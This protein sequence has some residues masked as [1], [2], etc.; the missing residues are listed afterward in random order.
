VPFELEESPR[1]EFGH[2][3]HDPARSPE[4]E[5]YLVQPLQ[6]SGEGDT[7]LLC[8]RIGDAERAKLLGCD[9]LEPGRGDGEEGQRRGV[10][11]RGS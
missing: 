10:G 8:H 5:V 6:S 9:G 7:A 3:R 4:L 11:H 1:R 2:T